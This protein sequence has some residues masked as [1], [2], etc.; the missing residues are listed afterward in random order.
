[1]FGLKKFWK[2][3]KGATAIVFSL[4]LIPVTAGFTLAIDYSKAI[5]DRTAYQGIVDSAALAG[6]TASTNDT[7]DARKKRAQDW[8]NAQVAMNGYTPA[9]SS[10]EVKN[11]QITVAATFVHKPMIRMMDFGD[12][13]IGVSA[14]ALLT[15]EKIRRVLDV[16]MCIDATGSMQN[17]INSVKARAQ[18]FS[19]DL[20]AALK[21]RNLEEFDYMRIRVVYYRDFAADFGPTYYPGWGWY[22]GHAM[23]KS[24]FFPQPAQKAQLESFIGSQSAT[25]GGDWPESSYECINEAMGSAWFKKNDTIPGTEYKAQEVYPAIIIWSDATALTIPHS[26]SINSGQYPA[27]MPQS[28]A[29]FTAK[30]NNSGVIDP[31]NKLLVHFG[32]CYD[33]TWSLARALTGYMCGGT[34]SD[35]NANM[36]NK[37]ADAMAVRYQNKLTRLSK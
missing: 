31:N 32:V 12:R 17:T 15:Q 18:S 20:N 23:V 33:S 9:T 28:Q 37:I 34:L 2:D 10:F 21:T 26:K 5:S 1:M 25:G 24:N 35:G 36:I 16:A 14:T 6:A 3:R 7:D 29:G 13:I 22:G 11:G 30:W 27:N 19:A 4:V 8:F